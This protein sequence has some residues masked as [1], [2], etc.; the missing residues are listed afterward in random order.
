MPQA[1]YRCSRSPR[2]YRALAKGTLVDLITEI[3]M[4][5]GATKW[6]PV[7]AARKGD[8]EAEE[9]KRLM[10]VALSGTRV[11]CIDNVRPGDPLG[12]TALE[13]A[14]TIGEDE[15]IGVL[16]D[17]VLGETRQSE[18]PW[19]CVVMATGN[20]LTVVGDMGRRAVLCR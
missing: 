16:A 17:R 8:K 3:A 19:R 20:N 15:I 5:R 18:V 4:G 13:M 7:S 1:T 11:L 12:T 10:A 9:R 14:L 6:A 2:T